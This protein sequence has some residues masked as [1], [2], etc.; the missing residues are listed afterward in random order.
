M[1]SNATDALDKLR[2]VSLTDHD[3]LGEDSE[4]KMIIYPEPETQR[5][6]IEDNGI[7]M[8]EQELIHNLGIIAKSG[9]REFIEKVKNSKD[10]ALIGQFGVGFLSSFIVAGEVVVISKKYNE[11]NAYLWASRGDGTFITR[12]CDDSGI[13]RGTRVI[14]RLKPEKLE[15]LGDAKI[16]ELVKRHSQYTPYPIGLHTIVPHEVEVSDDEEEPKDGDKEEPKDGDKEEPKDGDEPTIEEVKEEDEPKKKKTKKVMKGKYQVNILNEIKPL[17]SKDPKEITENEYHD[18]YKSISDDW[19]PSLAVKHFA[20]EGTIEYRAIL[21]IP[22]AAPF[23]L[24][25]QKQQ[26]N[27]VK[28]YVRN[29]FVTDQVNDLIPEWLKFIR[30]V[31]DSYDLPLNVSR[32]VLQQNKVMTLMK[33]NIIKKV[34]ELVREIS[35]DKEKYK[36]F[37]SNFGK[38]IKLGIHEE[39]THRQALCEFLR[40]T[41][42]KSKGE[43]DEFS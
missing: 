14:L 32:E 38:N 39:T 26:R 40:F 41:S 30:G 6:I 27:N 20:V 5:L 9:T 25:E 37:Y 42:T 23:D 24:F 8:S 3:A 2:Y 22:N 35:L 29:V 10:T 1:I 36:Q 33:K 28:L 18:F 11:E 21:Y 17:W 34:I 19:Q 31:V 4:L 13:K 16:A 12:Q 15:Y 43:L 7:G